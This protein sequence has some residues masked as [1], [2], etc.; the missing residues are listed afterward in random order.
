MAIREGSDY[1]LAGEDPET[2]RLDDVQ[3]WIRV[4]S[5]LVASADEW[6]APAEKRRHWRARLEFWRA[7]LA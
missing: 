5:E 4:Y 6:K 7:K 1:L 3:H 2:G